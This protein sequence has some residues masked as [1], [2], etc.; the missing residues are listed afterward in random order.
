MI[1]ELGPQTIFLHVTHLFTFLHTM[2]TCLGT[3]LSCAP[4]ILLCVAA[5]LGL[6]LLTSVVLRVR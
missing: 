2:G 4:H 6:G 5:V 3:Q 1:W